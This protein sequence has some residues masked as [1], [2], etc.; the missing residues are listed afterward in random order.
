MSESIQIQVIVPCSN[1][2]TFREAIRQYLTVLAAIGVVAPDM[3]EWG[4]QLEWPPLDEQVD[5]KWPEIRFKLFDTY[6]DA[7]IVFI[8]FDNNQER[9]HI[10][11]ELLFDADA[12]QI[13]SSFSST[14]PLFYKDEAG[15]MFW[16]IMNALSEK[17]Y[18]EGCYLTNPLSATQS[19]KAVKGKDSHFWWIELAIVPQ[20]VY[21]RFLPVPAN[22]VAERLDTIGIFAQKERWV[23][24]PWEYF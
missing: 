6:F 3:V 20:N 5:T 2:V 17:M 22:F 4:K 11:L 8:C 10:S 7:R 23:Q 15:K 13:G 14:N 24:M 9:S 16:Y 12:V 21:T 1:A 19:W 18:H